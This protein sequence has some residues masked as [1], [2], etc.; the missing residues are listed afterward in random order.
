MTSTF[1]TISTPILKS[2]TLELTPVEAAMLMRL[3]GGTNVREKSEVI[4][5][6]DTNVTDS[7]NFK[8]LGIVI[9]PADVVLLNQM[10]FNMS[11]MFTKAAE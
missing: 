6:P 7:K 5:S 8:T 3:L 2:V 9:D 4:F 1:K 10:Y 11:K